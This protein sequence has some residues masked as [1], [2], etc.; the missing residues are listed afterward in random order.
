MSG[1]DNTFDIEN[2]GVDEVDLDD[3]EWICC[4]HN[5]PKDE[6]MYFVQVIPIY[7]IIICSLVHLISGVGN[8]NIWNVLLGSSLGYLLPQPSMKTKNVR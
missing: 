5:L 4:G 1:T 7:C 6:I 2:N 3:N 8:D